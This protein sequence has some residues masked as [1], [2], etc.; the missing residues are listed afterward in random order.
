MRIASLILFFD[1]LLVSPLGAQDA[2]YQ[3]QN[4]QLP[5]PPSP[6]P[7]FSSSWLRDIQ[8]WRSERLER[9][10]YDG[11]QYARPEL[12]WAQ[13]SFVQPQMMIEDSYF[14]DPVLEGK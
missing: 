12:K 11:S 10:G 7:A 3:P 9:M 8:H 6:T 13:S 2:V 14:C 5:G 4:E 1:I